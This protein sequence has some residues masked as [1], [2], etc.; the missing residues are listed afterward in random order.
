M[1]QAYRKAPLPEL[2]HIESDPGLEVK[3]LARLGCYTSDQCMNPANPAV[4]RAT[5]GPDSW[6]DTYGKVDILV[7][8]VGT[9]DTVTGNRCLSTPLFA[10]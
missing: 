7:A 10:D 1:T 9:G 3:I 5:T 2:V 8:G 6:A 4:Y